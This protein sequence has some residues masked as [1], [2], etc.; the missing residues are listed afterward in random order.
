MPGGSLPSGEVQRS[1]ETV[2]ALQA[3]HAAAPAQAE[4]PS[5]A[6]AFDF[7]SYAKQQAHLVNQALD[8]LVPLQHPES[9]TEPMRCAG[10]TPR[11]S[12]RAV[13]GPPQADVWGRVPALAPA[14]PG[15][16]PDLHRYSTLAGGKRVRPLLCLASCR[17]VGGRTEDAL[18][19]ACAVEIL[20]TMCAS[21]RRQDTGSTARTARGCLCTARGAA[22]GL[23]SVGH[24]STGR[25]GAATCLLLPTRGRLRRSLIHDDLPSMVCPSWRHVGTG[26]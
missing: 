10:R 8:R 26:W 22:C 20:H 15:R 2:P 5:A 6:P 17:L 11:P 24:T 25:P 14:E 9:I 19:T 23:S 7:G 13:P 21:A 12:T 3:C 1:P 4:A 16:L 18:N